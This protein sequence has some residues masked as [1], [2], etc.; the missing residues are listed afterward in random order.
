L[1]SVAFYVSGHGY[2]HA[3]RQVEIINAFARRRPD[4]GIFVRS[5]AARWLLER[6][7]HAPFALDDRA[8]DTGVVQ[9]DSLR[10]DARATIE[11]AAAFYESFPIRVEEEAAWLRERRVGFVV[12]DAPPLACA[13]A[14]RAGIESV[15]AANFTWDW[16]YREY[17]EYL[18]AA[19]DLIRTIEDAYGLAAAAWRLPFH[20][21][22]ETFRTIRDMPLVA[23]H[24]TR[25]REATRATLG[26]PRD[27]R[28]V[29]PSF[30]GYGVAGL[31]LGAL[32]LPEGW[33][34]VRGLRQAEVYDAGVA[35]QDLVHAV[36]AVIT[37]PGYGIVSE[38]IANGTALVY[39]S[40]GRFREYAVF[41]REMP[42]YL[43]CAYLDNDALI[44]GR[45][46]EAIDAAFRAPAPPE[47]PRTDGADAAADMIAACLPGANSSPPRP[48][49]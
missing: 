6:T 15:V 12:S 23:R 16:I 29:L 8:C 11:E 18:D 24:S 3:S 30:G 42:K 34:V 25:P 39:T 35:Y 47:R 22:F 13:A 1:P 37:K 38:C 49:P 5:S 4:A 46:R 9:V 27:V 32:D 31:D 33:D 26:L 2:G 48:R 40:R 14:A 36:D 21:G 20:G 45:W 44:A 41:A 28:L 17:A 10:L 19:P 43:R 7:I